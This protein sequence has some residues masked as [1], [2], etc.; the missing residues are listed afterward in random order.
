MR[1]PSLLPCSRTT[2]PSDSKPVDPNHQLPVLAVLQLA[3]SLQATRMPAL[4]SQTDS[5]HRINQNRRRTNNNTPIP[6]S[7][8]VILY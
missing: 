1:T 2:G 7:L 4:Q 3:R 6:A 8:P 5:I